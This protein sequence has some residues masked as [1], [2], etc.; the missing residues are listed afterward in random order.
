MINSL[1]V[2][3]SYA[4]HF[5]LC[6]N[7]E[8]YDVAMEVLEVGLHYHP[9]SDRLIFQRGVIHAMRSE[10]E[11]AEHDFQLASQLAPE[12]NL[13]YVGLGINYMQAGNLPQ[14]IQSLEERIKQKPKDAT[15]QYLLGEA[16][17]RSGVRP[18]QSGFDEAKTALET[19][20]KLNPRFAPAQVDLARLYIKENRLDDALHHLEQ[21]RAADPKDKGAYSQLAIVYRRQGKPELASTVLS[22]LTK[23]NEEERQGDH[24]RRL[25]I[26]KQGSGNS[27]EVDR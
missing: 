11:D 16:L 22:N 5:T 20:V 19:S 13:S 26:V 4:D 21:A 18:G 24:T 7:Y 23:L 9:Q 6:T 14:A 10:F 15:L 12:K 8:A 25:R 17:T 3:V 1:Y 27:A 2:P